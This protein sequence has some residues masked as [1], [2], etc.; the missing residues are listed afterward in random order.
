MGPFGV[1]GVGCGCG[2]AGTATG[3]DSDRGCS[4]HCG[5]RRGVMT[6]SLRLAVGKVEGWP[7][8]KA[9]TGRGEGRA[10]SLRQGV[11]NTWSAPNNYKLALIDWRNWLCP[12]PCRSRRVSPA[13]LVGCLQRRCLRQLAAAR[14]QRRAPWRLAAGASSSACGSWQQL[15]ATA[16]AAA[17]AQRAVPA[18]RPA[19]CLRRLPAGVTAAAGEAKS[20]IFWFAAAS[21]RREDSHE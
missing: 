14:A 19:L 11:Q 8:G 17:S 10:N 5:V 12:G 9:E 21:Q 15:P 18:Q 16:L 1:G 6:L 4:V 20:T 7:W 13:A 2:R 3:C